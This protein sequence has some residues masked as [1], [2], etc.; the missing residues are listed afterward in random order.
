MQSTIRRPRTHAEGVAFLLARRTEH[1]LAAD[2]QVEQAARLSAAGDP[3]AAEEFLA[4]ARVSLAA[5]ARLAPAP[6]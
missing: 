1:L 6:R 3:A 5:A 2:M 4:A